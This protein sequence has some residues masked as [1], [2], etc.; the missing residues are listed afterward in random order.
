MFALAAAWLDAAESESLEAAFRKSDAAFAAAED[1][2]DLVRALA[3][4]DKVARWKG[5]PSRAGLLL[6]PPGAY[7]SAGG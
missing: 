7:S 4:L 3:V 2:A 6:Q 5:S 1:G